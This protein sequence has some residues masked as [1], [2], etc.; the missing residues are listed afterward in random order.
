[1]TGTSDAGGTAP[2]SAEP[3][4]VTGSAPALVPERGGFDGIR[5]ELAPNTPRELAQDAIGRLVEEWAALT[6]SYMVEAASDAPAANDPIPHDDA[7][8]GAA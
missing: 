7:G 5:V 2:N 4:V 3:P 6:Y 1:V 8:V